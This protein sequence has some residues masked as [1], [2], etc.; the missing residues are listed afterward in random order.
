MTAPGGASALA[1]LLSPL[2]RGR[3]QLKNRVVFPGHQTL[4]SEGGIIGPRMR[5]YY[6]ERARGGAAAIVVEG[7]AVHD[8]T[9]KFPNYLLAHDPRIVDS[10]NGLAAA[11]HPHGCKGILQLAHSGS[12]MSSH[13][14]RQALWAPSAVRSAISPELPHA[15][16]DADFEQLLEGYDTAARHVGA[17]DIDGIEVHAAHEYL[18]GQFLSPLNNLRTDRWGG[19]LENRAR[20]L[21]EVL[22]RVRRAAGDRKVIGVRL[23]GSDLTPGGLEPA[24]Y[25]QVAR[26]IEATGVV[27]YI[28]VTAGT[29]RD[30]NMIV[31]PMDVP[32]GVFADYAAEIRRH[33]GLP[34][35]AV[36]RIKTPAFAESVLAAGKADVV[37]V[38]RALIADPFWVEKAA[39]APETIRPCIGCNQGCFGY[40]YTNR[41]ITCTVNPAVGR[42]AELGAGTQPPAS[43][44]RHVLVGGG[45]PAGMEAAITAAQRGHRVTLLEAGPALGG[46]VLAAGWERSRR[47]LLEIT[48]FQQQEL[49]RLGVQVRTGTR[50]DA[51][52]IAAAGADAV[53]VATGSRPAASSLPCD[54]SVDVLAPAEVIAQLQTGAAHWQGRRVTVVDG[55]GHFP[56]Y[57]PAEALAAAGASVTLVTAKLHAASLLDNG[58]MINT[59][60]RLGQAGVKV[61]SQTATLRIEAGTVHARH[62]FSGE[63]QAWPCDAVV[64]ALGN[65][66]DDTLADQPDVLRI[67]DCHAPRTMLDAIRDGHRAGRAV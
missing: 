25:A 37:A 40:L 33:V 63:L 16:R 29:S 54:G 55:V 5:A 7:A 41:P 46:Q 48:T 1:T 39:R 23:N 26:M 27:D 15:M 11:L 10:L 60:R 3:L 8:T 22:Q 9:V 34:V 67:G 24:D 49:Q 44:P 51:A 6:A 35:F 4:F 13:D 20:L 64:A 21:L 12:R 57:A 65:V 47:E 59:L 14:S 19:S 66:A 28:S 42:E 61:L 43:P 32:H 56:A 17:S 50:L 53:I 18:L 30:N 45:G 38:C 52:A 2:H 62:V 36:G 31:P 58:S